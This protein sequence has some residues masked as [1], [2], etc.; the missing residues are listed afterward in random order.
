MRTFPGSAGCAEYICPAVHAQCRTVHQQNTAGY[1]LL[2]NQTVEGTVFHK[3][4]A[5]P[6]IGT[7]IP[8]IP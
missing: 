1:K 7:A 8:D 6:D 4:I 3:Y 5:V 2:N